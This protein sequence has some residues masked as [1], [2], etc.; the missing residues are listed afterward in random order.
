M[1]GA[2][3]GDMP[4]EGQIGRLCERHTHVHG[5]EREHATQ[6]VCAEVGGH[7]LVLNTMSVARDGFEIHA[8][9]TGTD[10]A[11]IHDG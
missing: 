7:A 5:R 1:R 3:Y 9:E 8:R 2:S 4:D 11:R 6:T 10:G